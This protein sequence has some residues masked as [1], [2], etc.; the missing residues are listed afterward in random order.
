MLVGLGLTVVLSDGRTSDPACR[1]D[2]I[3]D[4]VAGV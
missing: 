1:I 4:G 3:P 2:F